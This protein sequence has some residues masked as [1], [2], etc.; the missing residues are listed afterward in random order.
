ML[1]CCASPVPLHFTD[2]ENLI[3]ALVVPLV[4]HPSVFMFVACL[5][6]GFATLGASGIPQNKGLTLGRQSV[7]L[8]G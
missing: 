8:M 1:G 7:G 5:C 6:K 4:S 2:Y 3:V